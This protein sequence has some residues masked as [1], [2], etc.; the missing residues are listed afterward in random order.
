M[1]GSQKLLSKDKNAKEN[2]LLMFY[3]CRLCLVLGKISRNEKMLRKINYFLIFDCLQS[4]KK[5]SNVNKITYKLILSY[6]IF[7]LMN[8]INKM[9]LK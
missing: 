1:F 7:I 9:G 5:K 3:L 4:W 8:I 2:N 6:L